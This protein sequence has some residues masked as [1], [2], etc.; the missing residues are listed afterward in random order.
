[1]ITKTKLIYFAFILFFFYGCAKRATLTGG[2]KDI[3]PPQLDS[4]KST[5]N[6]QTHFKKQKI[7]LYFN[8]WITLKN[9]N[10]VLISPPLKNKLKIK[11]KGKKVTIEFDPKDTLDEKTSYNINFGN[12]IV[13]FTEGNPAQNLNFVFSTGDY[14]DS[15]QIKGKITDYNDKAQKDVL[16]MLYDTPDDSVVVKQKPYYF[17][18]TDKKGDFTI[19]NIKQG[20]FKLFVLKDA[21]NDFLYNSEKEEIAFLDTLIQIK[22]D[23]ITPF[24]KLS[25]F[26]PEPPLRVKEKEYKT[27]GKIK[28]TF[29]RVPH[30]LN[31]SSISP[32]PVYYEQQNDSLLVWL[33]NIP[34]SVKMILN[35]EEK[36]DTL[37]IKRKR[38]L[39]DEDSLFLVSKNKNV[40]LLAGDTLK[41]VFNQPFFIKDTTKISLLDTSGL[42]INFN[43]GIDSIKKRNLLINANWTKDKEYKLQILPG[44]IRGIFDQNT[45]TI[46]INIKVDNKENYASLECQIDS[47]QKSMQYIVLLK[48]NKKLIKKTIVKDKT[49]DTLLCPVL[50]PGKY[51]LEIIVDNNKNG[52]YDSG[53]Y[54]KKL[55]PEKI[56]N[57][58]L[59]ELKKNWK[60]K[61]NIILK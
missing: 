22:P 49:S 16:V 6:Y 47:L 1:M 43:Y 25:I 40:K 32:P 3:T 39:A 11:Q 44:F 58:Q 17:A 10:K 9:K 24:Y 50:E 27:K 53:D 61:E 55:K 21:N 56:Y 15:L 59:K 7:T 60:Q 33:E 36:T 31:I 8:E 42:K 18:I 2:P 57:F 29:N 45:D 51:K 30:K 5:K 4:L 19:S 41:L 37:L 14:I 23:S 48:K 54:F 13:D 20:F 35:L 46:D 52:R 26:K 34:D 38:I 28:I 12:S